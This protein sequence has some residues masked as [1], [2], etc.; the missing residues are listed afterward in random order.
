MQN[1]IATAGHFIGRLERG[2]DLLDAL[3][4]RIRQA[5]VQLGRV[6]AIGA[7]EKARVGFYDQ[8]SRVYRYLQFDRPLEIL[9]LKG[10]VSLK[11][12]Q[13]ML[14]AHV[15]FGDENG[16]AFGGHLAP[17]TV[18]FACE[19]ILE[20]FAGGELHRGHDEATGLPLWAGKE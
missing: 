11:E 15:T 7:V 1:A 3:T 13:P 16:H 20:G 18:V 14:H 9:A 19:Y 2:V 8:G 10:N 6:E 17:G 12:G 5:G 4:E